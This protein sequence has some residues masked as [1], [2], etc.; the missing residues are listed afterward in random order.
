MHVKPS[1]GHCYGCQPKLGSGSVAALNSK[2][3]LVALVVS[4]EVE[5]AL[6]NK[7]ITVFCL[8][9]IKISKT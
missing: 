9:G 7:N 1:Q 5:S 4:G 6:A 2:K 8:L 3:L